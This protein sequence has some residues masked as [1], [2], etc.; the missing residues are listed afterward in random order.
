MR[1]FGQKSLSALYFTLIREFFSVNCKNSNSG[2]IKK[3]TF[4]KKIQTFLNDE[5]SSFKNIK[6]KLPFDS[7]NIR[8]SEKIYHKLKKN[9]FEHE[10]E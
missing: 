2:L 5:H 3:F 10:P 7:L 6:N 8:H 4:N 9:L 1:N